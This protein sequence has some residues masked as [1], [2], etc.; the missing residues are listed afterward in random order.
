MKSSKSVSNVPARPT[1]LFAPFVGV[2]TFYLLLPYGHW[3]TTVLWSDAGSL[4]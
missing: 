1:G 3:L 2:T 4:P